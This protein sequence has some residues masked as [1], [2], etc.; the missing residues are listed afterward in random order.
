MSAIHEHLVEHLALW[1]A[2]TRHRD[3]REQAASLLDPSA[4]GPLVDPEFVTRQV[5]LIDEL[6]VMWPDDIPDLDA[7]P[8]RHLFAVDPLLTE[9][10]R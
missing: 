10:G 8:E 7:P 6:G 1:L 4:R 3:A 5:A 2:N 9:R